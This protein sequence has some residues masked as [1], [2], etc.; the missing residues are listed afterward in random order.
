L[1]A[2]KFSVSETVTVQYAE[3]SSRPSKEMLRDL[4]TM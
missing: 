2:V 4:L 1:V 3:R